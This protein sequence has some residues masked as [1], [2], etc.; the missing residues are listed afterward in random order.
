MIHT[1]PGGSRKDGGFMGGSGVWAPLLGRVEGLDKSIE[2]AEVG[3]RVI[4]VDVGVLT[5][6]TKVSVD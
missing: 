1:N 2:A 4:D 6:S 3:I 5:V